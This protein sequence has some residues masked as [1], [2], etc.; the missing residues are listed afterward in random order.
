MI[1]NCSTTAFLTNSKRNNEKQSSVK[2]RSNDP[3]LSDWM[4][5]WTLKYARD[6]T[7]TNIRLNDEDDSGTGGLILLL[8]LQVSKGFQ[9]SQDSIY[10]RLD[11][12]RNS[13]PL[14]RL[15]TQMEEAQ[16]IGLSVRDF[17]RIQFGH[18]ITAPMLQR[19][20]WLRLNLICQEASGGRNHQNWRQ[21]PGFSRCD[22]CR[23]NPATYL[24]SPDDIHLALAD[25]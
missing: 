21:N 12:M 9:G 8:S 16:S 11:V 10:F 22:V 17:C 19:T 25:Q 15:R 18:R 14:V 13:V 7:G 6:V 2:L 1:F 5:Q 3:R 24:H 23:R 4:A 20:H